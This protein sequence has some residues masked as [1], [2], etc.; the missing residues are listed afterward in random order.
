[1]LRRA[2][3]EKAADTRRVTLTDLL[4]G[5][6]SP[7]LAEEAPRFAT[8]GVRRAGRRDDVSVPVED[9]GATVGVRR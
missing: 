3:E 4:Q 1:M 6:G 8:V 9:A 5:G 7:N 2:G